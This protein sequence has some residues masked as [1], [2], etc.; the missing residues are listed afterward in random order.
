MVRAL[1]HI[2]YIFHEIYLPISIYLATVDMMLDNQED[3]LTEELEKQK[4]KLRDI[5]NV[6]ENQHQLLRLIIQVS[7]FKKKILSI[8]KL[9]LSLFF[10]PENGN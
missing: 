6:L 5:S 8:F 10:H 3:Y 2:L 1:L 9:K 4:K 7:Q